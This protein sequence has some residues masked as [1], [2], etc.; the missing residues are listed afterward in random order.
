MSLDEDDAPTRLLQV[1]A[2]TK[3]LGHLA[4]GHNRCLAT[5]QRSRQGVQ[6]AS[7]EAMVQNGY[8]G[9][10][11]YEREAECSERQEREG[12]KP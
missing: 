5:R 4:T 9:G 1:S 10:H 3:C 7:F 8:E 12:R 6:V 11:E 2:N